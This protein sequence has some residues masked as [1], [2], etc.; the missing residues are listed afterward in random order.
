[1]KRRTG[2]IS[3]RVTLLLGG[4]KLNDINMCATIMCMRRQSQMHKQSPIP[5]KQYLPV[6]FSLRNTK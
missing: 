2:T 5:I 4:A 6:L 1:M 3:R